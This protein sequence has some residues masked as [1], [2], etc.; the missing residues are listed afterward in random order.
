MSEF[1][2]QDIIPTAE[3]TLKVLLSACKKQKQR[4]R[5]IGIDV[6]VLTSRFQYLLQGVKD[7]QAIQI[8]VTRKQKQ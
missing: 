7:V 8:N 1:K 2:S 3:E 6:P 4:P 5:L